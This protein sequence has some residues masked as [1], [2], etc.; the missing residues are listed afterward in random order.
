MTYRIVISYKIG[1]QTLIS[2]LKVIQLLI[3]FIRKNI[4]LTQFITEHFSQ[5]TYLFFNMATISNSGTTKQKP[6]LDLNGYSY[7][8]DRSTSVK[9]YWRCIKFYSHHCRSRLHTCIITN[10]IVK[11]PTDHTCTFDGTTLECRKFDDQII[12]RTLNT[13]EPPDTIITHCYKGRIARFLTV[14]FDNI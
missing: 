4:F 6:R 13:Q 9:T 2:G 12:S 7:V 3:K 1:S 5:Y 10:N 11:S 8:M 14:T